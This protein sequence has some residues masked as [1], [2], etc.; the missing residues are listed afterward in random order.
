MPCQPSQ[1]APGWGLAID[2]VEQSAL[3]DILGACPNSPVEVT[4]AR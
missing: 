3:T 2:P 4:L 1:A